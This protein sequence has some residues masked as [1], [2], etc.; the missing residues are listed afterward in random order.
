LAPFLKRDYHYLLQYG[1]LEL[2]YG[3]LD[4]A[5]NYIEQ[6]YAFAPEDRLVVNTRG[7]LFY[8]QACAANLRERADKLRKDAREIL[9]QQMQARP[10]DV[11]PKHM[12][13][14]Q[15]LN[16]ISVWLP[17]ARDRKQP[18][19]ELLEFATKAAKEHP[20]SSDMQDVFRR[21][22]DAYLDTAKG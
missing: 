20:S 10:D 18:L 8:K 22:K 21:I 16:W 4:A 7:Y 9:T 14:S 15:E 2:E 11:Y 6:A 12:L 1:S 3:E 5:A 17:Y 13:C 19:T